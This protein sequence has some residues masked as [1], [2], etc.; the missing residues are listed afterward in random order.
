M[1][2]PLTLADFEGAMIYDSVS[3][4]LISRSMNRIQEI[5]Q[6][7][8][9]DL[10]LVWIPYKDRTAF[11]REPFA[12]IHSPVGAPEYIVMF[13]REDEINESLLARI[14]NNDNAHGNVLSKLEAQEAARKAIKLKKEME[15]AEIAKELVGSIVRSPLNTYRHNGVKYQ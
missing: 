2:K 13:L 6:D 15:E 14:W 10:R 9:P 1:G 12:L 8:N 7:Y 3:G 4:E 5:I 11:D